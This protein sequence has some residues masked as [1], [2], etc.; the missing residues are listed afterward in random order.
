[1]QDISRNIVQSIWAMVMDAARET[2]KTLLFSA[3]I[4]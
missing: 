1:M 3:C 2:I 4:P